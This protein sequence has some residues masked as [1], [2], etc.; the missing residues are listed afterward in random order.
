LEGER[1]KIVAIVAADV[2]FYSKSRAD[3]VIE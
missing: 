3:E 2:I 1:R